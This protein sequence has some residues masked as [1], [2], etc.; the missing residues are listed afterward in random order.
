MF[1]K[2]RRMV[3]DLYKKWHQYLAPSLDT[4]ETDYYDSIRLNN[5]TIPEVW[6]TSLKQLSAFLAR[7]S[8]LQVMVFIDEYDAPVI[9][10]YEHKYFDKVRFYILP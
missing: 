1:I 10:A 5:S 3:S 9:D 4:E 2:F 7:A 8:K 6:E